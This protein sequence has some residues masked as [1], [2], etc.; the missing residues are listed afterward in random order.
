MALSP[1]R[2]RVVTVGGIARVVSFLVFLLW[3]AVFVIASDF[4]L[5]ADWKERKKERKRDEVRG[6]D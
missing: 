5:S 3:F 6:K 4:F 1:V 2:P